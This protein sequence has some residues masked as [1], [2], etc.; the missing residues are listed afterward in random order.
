MPTPSNRRFAS[1]GGYPTNRKRR[2]QISRKVREIDHKN[3]ALL[4]R[5][6]TEFGQI[7]SRRRTG[8]APA[9]QRMI[10]TAIKRARTLALL[11]FINH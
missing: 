11:P 3:L 2:A 9:T 5:Y 4:K 6:T 8:N 7:E 1:K 10:A